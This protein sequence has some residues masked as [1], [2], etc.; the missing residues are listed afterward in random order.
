MEEETG[1]IYCNLSDNLQFERRII[2]DIEIGKI[3]KHYKGK[4]IKVICKGLNS[5]TNEEKKNQKNRK[6]I[7][8]DK[9]GFIVQKIFFDEV[10]RKKEY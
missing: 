2:M 6:D 7:Q 8:N 1:L 4:L 5:E 10:N 9:Y 3:Y